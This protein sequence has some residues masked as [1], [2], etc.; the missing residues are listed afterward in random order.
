MGMMSGLNAQAAGKS[1]QASAKLQP[2]RVTTTNPHLAYALNLLVSGD[3]KLAGSSTATSKNTMAGQAAEGSASKP[4]GTH[5]L[6]SKEG[7]RSAAFKSVERANNGSST[8]PKQPL[9]SLKKDK[10]V[11]KK[12][13]P[14]SYAD[15][16]EE[17]KITSNDLSTKQDLEDDYQDIDEKSIAEPNYLGRQQ[18]YVSLE[19]EEQGEPG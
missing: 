17:L 18:V 12:Q 2:K 10:P 19:K 5:Q 6:E 7:A 15:G 14:K 3:A 9:S 16:Q 1:A 4:Y 11:M 13:E 8:K